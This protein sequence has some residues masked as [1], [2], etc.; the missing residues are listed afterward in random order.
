MHAF[1][2]L[3][4]SSADCGENINL[5]VVV[6]DVRVEVVVSL[7]VVVVTVHTAID[8]D[9]YEPSN[10]ISLLAFEF[11]QAVPQSFRLND[12]A[13]QNMKF[14]FVTLDTSHFE[15]SIL[16]DV[17]EMNMLDISLTMDTS[18][19]EISPL[20]DVAPENM[21]LILVTLDTSQ[22]DMSALKCIV[23]ENK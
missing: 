2:A 3:F 4:S 16:K 8:I 21:K 14:I 22:F 20:K 11:T 1:T 19:F 12:I 6:V 23:S 15:M 10:I 5:W 9:P 18:H 17:A 13:S 7:R